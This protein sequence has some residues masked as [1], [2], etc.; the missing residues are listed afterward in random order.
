MVATRTP[1]LTRLDEYYQ[2]KHKDMTQPDLLTAPVVDSHITSPEEQS[3]LQT[4][5]ARILQRLREG[6]VTGSELLKLAPR[7]GARI[8]DLRKAGYRITL[9]ERDYKTGRTVYALEP[10][11]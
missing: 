2:S 1:T 11:A 8:K 9:V 10:S 4:Q 3:R 7:F 5:S 6:P